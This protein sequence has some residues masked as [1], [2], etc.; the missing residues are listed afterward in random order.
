MHT[1]SIIKSPCQ[2][3]QQQF[4]NMQYLILGKVIGVSYITD[5]FFLPLYVTQCF[6]CFHFSGKA[7]FLLLYFI[8]SLLLRVLLFFSVYFRVSFI[9]FTG[10]VQ[11]QSELLVKEQL[12]VQQRY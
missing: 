8:R 6:S 11:L 1:S 2:Q 5:G 12:L 3:Q 10:L 4:Y 7:F 9:A